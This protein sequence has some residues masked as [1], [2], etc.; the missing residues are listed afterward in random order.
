MWD[1]CHL[2]NFSLANSLASSEGTTPTS[3]DQ[4]VCRDLQQFYSLS[5]RWMWNRLRWLR[6]MHIHS[7]KRV[8]FRS[9]VLCRHSGKLL[10]HKQCFPKGSLLLLSPGKFLLC[11]KGSCPLRPQFDVFLLNECIIAS[12]ICLQLERLG[13]FKVAYNFDVCNSQSSHTRYQRVKLRS[14]SLSQLSGDL[15]GL[16]LSQSMCLSRNPH[17]PW[18]PGKKEQILQEQRQ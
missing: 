11:Y 10:S 13:V 1:H 3:H 4:L 16:S 7:V 9:D 17:H 12:P 15:S 5:F 14:S 8:P 6:F 2:A 18:F